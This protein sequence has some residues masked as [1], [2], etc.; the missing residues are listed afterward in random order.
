MLGLLDRATQLK[1]TTAATT[2]CDCGAN[3]GSATSSQRE[4]RLPNELEIIM[5]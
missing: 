5:K 3:A 4:E 1:D 2:G